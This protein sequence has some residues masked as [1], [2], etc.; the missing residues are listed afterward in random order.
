MLVYC[1]KNRPFANTS[2]QF[3]IKKKT[4]LK[5]LWNHVLW[6]AKNSKIKTM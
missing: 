1:H 6:P 3:L 5:I 2:E 4:D